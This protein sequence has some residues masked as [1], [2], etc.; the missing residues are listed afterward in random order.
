MVFNFDRPNG[1]CTDNEHMNGWA[2]ETSLNW[3]ATKND[4]GWS[5]KLAAKGNDF[6][7]NGGGRFT[8]N[9]VTAAFN[10]GG[11]MK[12]RMSIEAVNGNFK[13]AQF[14][15]V[16]MTVMGQKVSAK[17][18]GRKQVDAIKDAIKEQYGW[19][20]QVGDLI[21]EAPIKNGARFLLWSDQATDIFEN[22]FDC[23]SVVEATGIQT[24]F[25]GMNLESKVKDGCA[26]FNTKAVAYIQERADE[27]APSA[28]EEV[29]FMLDQDHAYNVNL[30]NQWIAIFA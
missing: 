2:G 6:N 19:I 20:K 1:V 12:G 21:K 5:S 27:K 8:E 11:D 26:E 23:T 4:D 22:E 15:K 10:A 18:P 14:Y 9:K 17:L 28:R 30:K 29:G 16:G 13:E 24:N 7:L 25:L 3:S